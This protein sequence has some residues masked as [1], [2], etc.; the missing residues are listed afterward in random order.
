M[1][2][3]YINQNGTV[4]CEHKDSFGRRTF[5]EFDNGQK[6]WKYAD[7]EMHRN[8][9]TEVPAVQATKQLQAHLLD[10]VDRKRLC[11]YINLLCQN[12]EAEWH[13]MEKQNN[14]IYVM[15]Y[16]EYPEGLFGIF[17]ML[18]FDD[19]YRMGMKEWPENLLPTDMDIWQ[20]RTALTYLQIAER[21]C[22][23]AIAEAMDDGTLLKLLL[24][25]EDL[26][27]THQ[28]KTQHW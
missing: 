24:R 7:W 9:I 23:G 16:P 25:L 27:N 12:R 18:G 6:E 11:E 1:K 20:I 15:G 21:F 22:T 26:L 13:P 19:D 28:G 10:G 5:R 14:G 3:Y 2:T 4:F 17:T 8:Q